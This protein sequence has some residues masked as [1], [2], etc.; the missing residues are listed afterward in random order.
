[1]MK[2]GPHPFTRHVWSVRTERL[3][4]CAACASVRS[5]SCAVV[6]ACAIL[7]PPRV[8]CG[9]KW[10]ER[11]SRNSCHDL[12]GALISASRFLGTSGEFP[13]QCAGLLNCLLSLFLEGIPRQVFPPYLTRFRPKRL[14]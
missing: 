9:E 13:S 6:A 8:R 7:R 4:S 10:H 5:E 2:T 1:R 11:F 14:L 3:K 12:F